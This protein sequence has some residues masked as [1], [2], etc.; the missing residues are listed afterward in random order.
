VPYTESHKA[1]TH[2][3]IVESASRA[4]R[5]HGVDGVCIAD[6]MRAANLTHGG[7]YA[8]FRSKTALV[9]EAASRGMQESRRAFLASAEEANPKA[10]LREI[11]R[12]YV[13]RQ[14]RDDAATGCAMPALVGEIARESDD[15]RHAFT[16]GVE[17][18]VGGLAAYTPGET[19]EERRDAALVLAAGMV[20][21]VALAR[22]VDDPELSDR[23]LLATRRYFTAAMAETE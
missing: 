9:A 17:D 13:S 2:A 15:V 21:A 18:I 6:L 11:I 22:A 5:E 7:F 3:R 23:I 12:R 16:A 20:G 4:F 1:R 19:T 14:H 10:P 8:H